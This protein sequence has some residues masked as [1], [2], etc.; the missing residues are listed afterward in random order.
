MTGKKYI[1]DTVKS[2][3]ARI[4]VLVHELQNGLWKQYYFTDQIK[5][6]DNIAK[7]YRKKDS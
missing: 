4:E 5:E 3:M 6:I 1:A 2:D 7:S